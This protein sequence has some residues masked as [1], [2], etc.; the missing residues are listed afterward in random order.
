MNG[1]ANAIFGRSLGV[2]L[3]FGGKA[4][5]SAARTGR[6]CKANRF[7]AGISGKAGWRTAL[8]DESRQDGSPPCDLLV[9]RSSAMSGSSSVRLAF[10]SYRVP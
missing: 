5:C 3:R 6:A 8:P 2:T 1:I 7:V 4:F 10:S 9:S